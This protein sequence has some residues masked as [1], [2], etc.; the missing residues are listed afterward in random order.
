MKTQTE[1]KDIY[2]H[3]TH[4]MYQ[5]NGELHLIN[6]T[7]HIVINCD[8][9]FNDLPHIVRLVIQGR[10]NTNKIIKNL[11][12]NTINTDIYVNEMKNKRYK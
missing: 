7:Q 11:L 10:E 6:D 2:I 8:T 9:F 3:E 4:T 1:L 5:E 12:W